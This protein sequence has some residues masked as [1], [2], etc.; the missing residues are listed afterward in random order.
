M[1]IIKMFHGNK[2][3]TDRD[4]I[5]ASNSKSFSLS[6][7][8]L[9]IFKYRLDHNKRRAVHITELLLVFNRAV[10][11]E[12]TDVIICPGAV[13]IFTSHDKMICVQYIITYRYVGPY[14][15]IGLERCSV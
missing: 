14:I 1:R 6:N 10:T 15:Y 11:M 9:K 4:I 3:I 7:R 8:T 2:Y 13:I 12:V 5:I